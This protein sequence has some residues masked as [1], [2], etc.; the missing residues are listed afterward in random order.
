[1]GSCVVTLQVDAKNTK[2][3]LGVYQGKLDNI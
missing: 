1:M 3:L 2:E